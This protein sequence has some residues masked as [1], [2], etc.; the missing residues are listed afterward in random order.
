MVIL[1]CLPALPRYVSHF[2]AGN[3]PRYKVGSGVSL[4][5]RIL[6]KKQPNHLGGGHV[7]FLD[8]SC[9]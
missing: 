1:R 5:F 6:N 2:D 8:L 7:L 4:N 3:L 9:G